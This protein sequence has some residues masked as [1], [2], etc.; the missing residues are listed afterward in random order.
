VPI[1][2]ILD[3]DSWYLT[4]KENWTA[5]KIEESRPHGSGI[6]AKFVGYNDPEKARQLTGKLIAVK[7]SQLPTLQK[8][9]YYWRDL[10]GL[11]VIDQHQKILGKVTHLLETGANDVLVI[12]GEKEH[13]VPYLLDKVI[14]RVDLEKGEIHINWEI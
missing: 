9:E 13:A 5:F 7:R 4:D 14:T 10:E 12:K 1:T 3:Y 8:N 2:N 6:V 11:T